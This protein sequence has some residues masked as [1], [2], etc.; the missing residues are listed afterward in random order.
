MESENV[1]NNSTQGSPLGLSSVYIAGA[2][3]SLPP[4]FYQCLSI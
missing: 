2:D 4:D 3:G 1:L